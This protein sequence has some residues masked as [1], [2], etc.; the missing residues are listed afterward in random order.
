[1][2]LKQANLEKAMYN[3]QFW[4]WE[5]KVRGCIRWG[6][7]L[8]TILWNRTKAGEHTCVHD[9]EDGPKLAFTQGSGDNGIDPSWDFALII[10]L[11]I[12]STFQPCCNWGF[13]FPEGECE[14]TPSNGSLNK[15]T[16]EKMAGRR[17]SLTWCK[18]GVYGPCPSHSWSPKVFWGPCNL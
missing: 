17:Q 14:G 9:G 4:N 2:P 12:G 16:R 10:L 7:P 15:N 1:M 13:V 6:S 5:V 18:L 11:V 8:C 3:E